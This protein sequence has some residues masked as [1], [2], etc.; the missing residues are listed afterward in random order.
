MLLGSIL[1]R[2]IYALV[3]CT[4]VVPAEYL[5]LVT[6]VIVALAIAMPTRSSGRPS[7]T[8]SAGHCGKKGGALTCLS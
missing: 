3:P 6:A 8:E 5:K 7:R 1:Y 2:F 4:K